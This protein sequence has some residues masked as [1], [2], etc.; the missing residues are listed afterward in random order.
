[1]LLASK[2][3]LAP[4]LV[5][6]LAAAT[7]AEQPHLV[8]DLNL[9]PAGSHPTCFATVGTHTFFSADA[10]T[11]GREPWVTDGT[12]T[13]TILLRDLAPG[14][15]SSDP[16]W[17]TAAGGLVYFRTLE[18]DGLWRTDGSSAGTLPV[19]TAQGSAMPAGDLLPMGE[20]L[21]VRTFGQLWIV[22]AGVGHLAAA[23][24]VGYSDRFF[25]AGD[26]AIA[27]YYIVPGQP[28]WWRSDGTDVG[29][30]QLHP[31][32]RQGIPQASWA[33]VPVGDSLVWF[34]GAYPSTKIYR[35]LSTCD[36]IPEQTAI[37]DG[38]NGVPVGTLPDGRILF[39]TF[40]ANL[41]TLWVTDGT[42]AGTTPVDELGTRSEV[43]VF[44]GVTGPDAAWFSTLASTSASKVTTLWRTDGTADGTT[45]V[46]FD[47][48]IAHPLAAVAGRV[49]FTVDVAL[50]RSDGSVAGT[51]QI[52][53]FA[54][55]GQAIPFL[56]DGP[57]AATLG[58]GLLFSADEDGSHGLE[59][60]SS[61]GSDTGLL[62][63]LRS[64]TDGLGSD[65]V[66]ARLVP[67]SS[68]AFIVNDESAMDAPIYVSDSTPGGT[69][70]VPG[71]AGDVR[72]ELALQPIATLGDVLFF[73]RWKDGFLDL[74]RA[75]G[76]DV[77]TQPVTSGLAS[78]DA[79]IVAM[80]ATG[81]K[82][83]FSTVGPGAPGAPE[84]HLWSS[85]GT[86][87]G[88][89]EVDAGVDAVV[90]DIAA[91][92]ETTFLLTSASA[93]GT[94]RAL[95][96]L[97]A[98]HGSRL[99]DLPSSAWALH[100][101]GPVVYIVAD[102]LWRSDG[103][104]EGTFA[105]TSDVYPSD[106]TA[107]GS[108][109]YFISWG[110][111]RQSDGTV[112]GTKLVPALPAFPETLGAAGGRLFFSAW[113][114]A[115]GYELWSSDG[116]AAGTERITDINPGSG[117]SFPFAITG[118]GERLFFL[119]D[120]GEHGIELWTLAPGDDGSTTTTTMTTST[121]LPT[122]ASTSST[123]TVPAAS[124]TTTLLPP[125]VTTTTAVTTIPPTTT[126]LPCST[127]RCVLEESL[128]SD[129]CRDATVPPRVAKSFS[130][131]SDLIDRAA[132]ASAGKARKLRRQ[133]KHVL[134]LAATA[135]RRS[136]GGR[137]PR[138]S[139]GCNEEI[140]EAVLSARAGLGA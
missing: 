26:V 44:A 123:T 140:Q 82:I 131:A 36:S 45:G 132:A 106:L 125:L 108:E 121:T 114:E 73:G 93:A 88:T 98:G 55:I 129:A 27:Q 100:T 30:C 24:P 109:L 91:T 62:R 90:F 120:D 68:R 48:E 21:F 96:R 67:G 134:A 130:R 83:L 80:A 37:V 126:T 53:P 113:E 38:A 85:D 86:P 78:D 54:L 122:T 79:S 110:G 3:W 19:L 137:T 56:G 63:D 105:L 133:A 50:W 135:A 70:E 65:D 119:A 112:L 60:Y 101:V 35:S 17:F 7:G 39:V 40:Q 5:T 77:G 58:D 52:A 118:I 23:L 127:V 22:E 9:R 87:D 128:A 94:G 13:G 69:H 74:W 15:A 57:G 4:V 25:S 115:T 14:S 111:L 47:S 34:E 46:A 61:D 59:P 103:T 72:Y 76:T 33:P 104:A 41:S 138:I 6:F 102:S 42:T 81:G 20:R 16:C 89:S 124:T 97:D 8:V 49:F 66:A 75:D 99:V 1:M 29:T 51:E 84:T 139:P 32:P 2:R 95:W 31:P 28:E 92:D 117:D 136:A 116:S 11:L 43:P 12:P 18:A 107:L 64:G 10:D 71:L